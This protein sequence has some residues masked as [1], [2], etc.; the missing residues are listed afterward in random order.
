MLAGRILVMD[1]APPS[2]MWVVSFVTALPGIRFISPVA[3]SIVL[4]LPFSIV[5]LHAQ[6][7]ASIC[8]RL[9]KPQ[10]GLGGGL[11][12]GL[13]T[14]P[15]PRARYLVEHTGGRGARTGCRRA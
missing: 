4:A 6:G 8:P 15:H 5:A 12:A 10:L 7:T 1:F 3:G 13:I 2:L 9:P 14:H 11:L